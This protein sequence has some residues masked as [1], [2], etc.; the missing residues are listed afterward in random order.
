LFEIT[1]MRVCCAS[2]P[3]LATHRDEN[4]SMDSAFTYV[5]LDV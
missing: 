3:V 5:R 2:R 1:S 4:M